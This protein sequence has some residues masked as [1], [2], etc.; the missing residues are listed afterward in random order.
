MKFLISAVFLGV[1]S[2]ALCQ[3]TKTVIPIVR[4][5][6]DIHPDG[7]YNYAYETANQIFAEEQGYLK[8]P[9]ILVKQ[10]QYQFTS[11]E[12]EVIRLVYTADENGFHPQGEHL[13]TPPPIP[14][15]ILKAL[16]YQRLDDERLQR[17][18]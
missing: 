4:Q 11:P 2:Y 17:S 1:L 5:L 9:Q 8:D 15:L 14:P 18:N 12:G 10:G 13:P 7:T 3:S 16:E 6:F